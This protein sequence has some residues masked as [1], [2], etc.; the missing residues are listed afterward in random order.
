MH[1]KKT[2]YEMQVLYGFF[3]KGKGE[4]SKICVL[5]L[6]PKFKNNKQWISW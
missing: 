6:Q 4:Y 5:L 3:F 2:N 1:K